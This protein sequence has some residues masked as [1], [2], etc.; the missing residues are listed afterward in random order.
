MAYIKYKEI[1]K[2]F[3]F[4]KVLNKKDLP[5]YIK[6]YSFDDEK[7]L[8]AYKTLTDHGVFTDKKIILFD[9]FG[10]KRQIYVI[11]YKAVST[12]SIIFSKSGAELLLYLDCGYPV[13]LKFVNMADV[14]KLR[15]RVLYSTIIRIV[16]NQKLSQT[17]IDRLVEDDFSF[18]DK[19]K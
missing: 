7:I 5:K 3:N 19:K 16:N 13:R 11:P 9:N 15:V 6:D 18:N 2:Y 4:S 1:T 10:F 12:C 14:D 17:D 8:A